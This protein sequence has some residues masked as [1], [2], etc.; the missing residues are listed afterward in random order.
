MQSYASHD[1]V[2]GVVLNKDCTA[3][4]CCLRACLCV[5]V[6]LPACA[7][8]CRCYHTNI[9][10]LLGGNV[11]HA[12]PFLALE[13]METSLE[14]VLYGHHDDDGGGHDKELGCADKVIWGGGAGGG[15]TG[16]TT[17]T[18]QPQRPVL[19]LEQ[20]LYWAMDIAAALAY[21]HPTCV[22]CDLSAANILISA[23]G[24]AKI[25][26][27]LHMH[28]HAPRMTPPVAYVAFMPTVCSYK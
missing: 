20:V 24:T 7:C 13:L 25:C 26:G 8:V 1:A 2:L 27:A 22:H 5:P 17:H 11:Q 4:Q 10:R 15:C 6:C 16:C 18:M 19:S 9:V 23:G 3:K 14:Q 12:Q 21:L 28:M